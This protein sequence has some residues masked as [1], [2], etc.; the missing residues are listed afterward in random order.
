LFE[1]D[2]LGFACATSGISSLN[3]SSMI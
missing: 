1:N 3:M 2:W